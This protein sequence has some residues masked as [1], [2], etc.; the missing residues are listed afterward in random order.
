MKCNYCTEH[1][2]KK[3]KYKGVQKY[4]CKRCGKYQRAEYRQRK[5][6]ILMEQQVRLLNKESVGIS[7]MGRI[8]QIPRS[9]AQML[10]E[11]MSVEVTKPILKESDQVYELDELYTFIG[12]K[13]NSCYIIYAINRRTRQVIDF[14][15]GARTKE[16]ISKVLKSIMQLSP[17][18]IYTDRLPVFNYLIT[19]DIHRSLRYKT[20]RI[21]R[22]NLT[23]RTH[24]KRLTRKTICY[25]K[26]RVMLEACFKLYIWRNAEPAY[27]L[28]I[29]PI[30]S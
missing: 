15:I 8:L 20:N 26:S 27:Q 12:S 25:S 18:R 5:Y 2:I 4:R 11:R 30:T 23:L 21:E 22:N 29:G 9:S 17:K 19:K 14:V 6:G 16:N 24:L 1:C 28:N 13:V 7:S 10:I 3:G